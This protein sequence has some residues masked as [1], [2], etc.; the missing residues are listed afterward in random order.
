MTD[1]MLHVRVVGDDDDPVSAN[2]FVSALNDELPDD[3]F[4]T[5]DDGRWYVERIEPA[6]VD[7]KAAM[8]AAGD[9]L[10]WRQLH[11]IVD[12]ALGIETP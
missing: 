7:Y 11:R 5:Q 2:R 1:L 8:E 10:R 3:W 4:N 9:H 12:A 6:V